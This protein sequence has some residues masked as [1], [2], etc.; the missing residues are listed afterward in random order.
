MASGWGW[1]L[2]LG[3][4][5][6]LAVGTALAVV[7][8]RNER[9]YERLVIAGDAALAAADLSAAIEAYTGAITLR[10]DSMA[11]HLKRG[12]A[13][14][15]RGEPE[16][17]LRDLRRAAELDPTA[18]R[19]FEWQGDVNAGLG[20]HARAAE[21]YE[22]SLALDDR[23]ADVFYKLAVARYRE[24]RAG[25]A[26]EPL[27]RAIALSPGL[28]EAHYLLGLSLRDAGRLD[29]ALAALG[30][31]ARL[32]PGLLEVREARVDVLQARGDNAR[33][34]DELAAL[35]ALEPERP[36]RAIAVGAAYAR[37]GRH[38]A[39]V[40]ALGRAA[41]R[42]PRSSAVFGAVGA[43]WLRAADGGD[44][45]ALDKALAALT[46]AATLEEPSAETLTLLGRARALAGDLSGAES[47][48]RRA[49]ER[50][51]VPPEALAR[52]GDVL[53]RRGRLGEARDALI[54]YASL[55]SGT[56]AV[57]AVAPRIGTL[58][59]RI[60]DPHTAAY[61]FEKAIAENGPTA[62]LFQRL[63]DAERDRGALGRAR[64]VVDDG[65]ALEPGHPGLRALDRALPR[66]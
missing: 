49:A 14:R 16:A 38:D 11:A 55:V 52:L 23:Q 4:S 25:A 51:P 44:A 58:S 7:S 3:A 2:A 19:V 18:P 64:E 22:Q 17:A 12:L 61:W 59:M 28:A 5:L 8:V 47:D 30:T 46:R 50:L 21:R 43:L 48:L 62:T 36:E 34:T 39:A 53:E 9:E 1:P 32:A 57:G 35:S 33:A 6:T 63:A 45:V 41:E 29:D 42:F 20:R 10:T 24:G 15:Q 37:Q 56:A 31:A 66:R 13:Y 26:L 54:D 27:H 60:G 65:L 40:V